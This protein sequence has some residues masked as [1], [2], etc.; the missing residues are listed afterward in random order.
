[1]EGLSQ[2]PSCALLAGKQH[3]YINEWVW[4]GPDTDVNKDLQGEVLG[5]IL[6]DI[7]VYYPLV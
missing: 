7:T 2:L 4:L 1:M 6:F 5:R 3:R